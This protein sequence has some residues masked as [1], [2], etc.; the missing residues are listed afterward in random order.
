MKEILLLNVL[1]FISVLF[2]LL[3]LTLYFDLS[4]EVS[5]TA[6]AFSSSST[7]I[8]LILFKISKDIYT[9][10]GERTTAILIYQDLAVIPILLLISFLTNDNLSIGEVIWNTFVSA[11]VI[12]NIY[13]LLEK[14]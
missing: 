14:E 8:V 2:I 10:Y 3:L 7:A 13:V 5:I 12:T 1:S 4:S 9:P 11:A 6:F